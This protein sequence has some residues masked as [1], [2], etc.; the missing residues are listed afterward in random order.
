MSLYNVVGYHI[1]D[2][3]IN[4]MEYD[5]SYGGFHRTTL[6]QFDDGHWELIGM[7][8][9]MED[10]IFS[11]ATFGQPGMRGVITILS[12]DATTPEEMG[13]TLEGELQ[14]EP[15]ERGEEAEEYPP[16][17]PLVP[18]DEELQQ[19]IEEQQMMDEKEVDKV[20]VEP[21][22][23]DKLIV[24]GIGLTS[25][26]VNRVKTMELQAAYEAV[27]AYKKTESRD[28]H[29]QV[30]AERPNDLEVQKHC[31]THLPYQPWCLHCIAHRGR[32][33]R[34][35]RHDAAKE[36]S[37]PVISFDFCTTKSLAEG[38]VEDAVPASLWMVLAD[39]QTGAVGCVPLK[40]KGQVKLAT[41]EVM[42]FGQGLGY[43]SV[44]FHT[45]NEPS[46]RK[47][48]RALLNAPHALG[49][50]T[51][52]TTAK[53]YDHANS[54]AE[55]SIQ[56]VRGLT[57]TLMEQLQEYIGERKWRKT[58]FIGKTENQDAF[59]CFDGEKILLSK[60]I[61]D[62]LIPL[63][64][65]VIKKR[66]YEAEAVAKKAIEEGREENELERM[67]SRQ[68]QQAPLVETITS[69]TSSASG[70]QRHGGGVQLQQGQVGEG[71]MVVDDT[72]TLT[73]LQGT[74][75]VRIRFADQPQQVRPTEE[76]GGASSSTRPTSSTLGDAVESS[77]TKKQKLNPV[78]KLKLRQIED[79]AAEKIRT[80]S[81][82]GETYFTMDEDVPEPGDETMLDDEWDDDGG[83]GSGGVLDCLWFDGPLE[84]MP[85]TPPAEID[86]QSG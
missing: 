73:A 45:D 15:R 9:K 10:L 58:L 36:G 26:L 14:I 25:S 83:E 50:P 29:F 2:T 76:E 24:K 63:D 70:L 6:I 49:S 54:L 32:P 44:C 8:E 28:P 13:F 4:P 74:E 52:I 42:P 16:E 43:H 68:V 47:I 78:K 39:S 21:F 12:D 22:S 48:L 30:P 1:S 3:F 41:S 69:S 64:S 55:N 46:V 40:S 23:V 57:G 60:S 67:K 80:I 72:T 17:I 71:E 62:S 37:I 27:Q 53:P 75:G 66:D 86:R 65:I 51:R 77:P 34:H 35:E 59:I 82:G 31:L 61:R 18:E 81:F 5:A 85:P 33:D 56:R 79:E 38:D 20:V 7:C 19:K 11:D 84:V